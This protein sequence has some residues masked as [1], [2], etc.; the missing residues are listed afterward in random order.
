MARRGTRRDLPRSRAPPLAPRVSRSRLRLHGSERETA[1]RPHGDRGEGLTICAEA[2]S[3]VNGVDDGEPL[4]FS[5]LSEH[6]LDPCPFRARRADVHTPLESALQS[7]E[8]RVHDVDPCEREPIQR[9]V[10][11]RAKWSDP[12]REWNDL[13]EL[14]RESNALVDVDLGLAREPD[15][16][17]E[18]EPIHPVMTCELGGANEMALVRLSFERIAKTFA[19]AIHRRRQRSRTRPLESR[20][21]GVVQS[22][23]S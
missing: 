8:S 1:N 13:R 12:E 23:G 17:I 5:S 20:N 4:G 16:Q 19:G 3:G 9:S 18:L 10:P 15:H 21:E 11:L 2:C 6:V 7:I 14:R 22:I